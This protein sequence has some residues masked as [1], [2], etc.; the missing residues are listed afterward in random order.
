MFCF[1]AATAACDGDAGR[2]LGPEAGGAALRQGGT[3][4]NA[5][6]IP[7][8][9]HPHGRTYDEWSA[10]WWQYMLSVPVSQ[11]PLLDET[12]AN[13]GVSQ[14][15][16]V[17]FLAGT[18]GGTAVRTECVVPTGVMLFFPILNSLCTNEPPPLT[19]TEDLA[20]CAA[21]TID[22]VTD[23]AVEIDGAPVEDLRRFRAASPAFGLTLPEDNLLNLFFGPVP[24]GSCFPDPDVG[25]CVPW[26]A[27]TDGFWLML[28]PLPPGEHTLHIFAAVHHPEL[29]LDFVV[30]VTFAPLTVVPRGEVS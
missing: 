22:L 13:C 3:A 1:F 4:S 26:V 17:F 12:G 10:A 29:G 28:P 15:G 30:D 23:L 6:V 14:T 9:A 19:P 5:R 18:L 16:H 8:Q 11:N 20:P 2:P 27:A 24:A 7:P 21:I 25:A